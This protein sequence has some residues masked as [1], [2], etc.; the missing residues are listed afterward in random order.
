MMR[1]TP[2]RLTTLQCSQIGLTLER[3]FTRELRTG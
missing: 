2:C 1:T 3:T